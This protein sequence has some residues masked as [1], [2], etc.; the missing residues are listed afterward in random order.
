MKENTTA[1]KEQ[2]Q[3]TQTEA[4]AKSRNFK[5]TKEILVD[6]KNYLPGHTITLT[7]QKQIDSL[8]QSKHIK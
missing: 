5:V 7:E 4:A 6:G 3:E 8:K 1:T 2:P